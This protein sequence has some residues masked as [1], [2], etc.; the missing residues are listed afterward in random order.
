MSLQEHVSL[1]QC[2]VCYVVELCV[3]VYSLS[4]C[5]CTVSDI[6]GHSMMIYTRIITGWTDRT[7][8]GFRGRVHGL[9]EAAI[10]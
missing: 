8:V 9:C 4:Y 3:F 5:V 2:D 10:G 6:G 1:V 7:D